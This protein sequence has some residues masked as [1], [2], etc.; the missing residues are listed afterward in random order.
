MLTQLKRQIIAA[1]CIVDPS[2][3]YKAYSEILCTRSI[4]LLEPDKW[5]DIYTKRAYCCEQLATQCLEKKEIKQAHGYFKLASSDTFHAMQIYLSEEMIA[6]CQAQ[7]DDDKKD[8]RKRARNDDTSVVV[9]K[10]C[11]RDDLSVSHML[12]EGRFFKR[13]RADSMEASATDCLFG[14]RTRSMSMTSDL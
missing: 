12:V 14:M 5:A 6:R 1:N 10:G 13:A 8:R 9:P 7:L 11:S 2:V 3:A 4:C